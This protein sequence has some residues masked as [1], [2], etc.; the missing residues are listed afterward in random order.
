MPKTCYKLYSHH[1]R[2]P[3]AVK[4][5]LPNV[6][7]VCGTAH[8]LSVDEGVRCLGPLAPC[9]GEGRRGGRL[10]WMAVRRVGKNGGDNE[11]MGVMTSKWRWW[12]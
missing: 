11:K 3:V 12:W 6:L 5:L 8:S 9:W 10:L 2:G 1:A 4:L 7:W